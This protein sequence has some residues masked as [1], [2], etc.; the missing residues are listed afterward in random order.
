MLP[1]DVYARYLRKEKDFEAS[2]TCPIAIC[3]PMKS[4]KQKHIIIGHPIKTSSVIKLYRYYLKVCG[5]Y[6]YLLSRKCH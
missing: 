2:Y 4:F 5:M 3:L 6:D 1:A